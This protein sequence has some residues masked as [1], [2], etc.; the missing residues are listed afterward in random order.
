MKPAAWCLCSALACL[1]LITPAL[2]LAQSADRT[3]SPLPPLPTLRPAQ[4]ITLRAAIQQADQANRSLKVIRLDLEAATIKRRAAYAALLPS[5]DATLDYA[6]VAGSTPG[7]AQPG[8]AFMDRREYSAGL[9]ARLPIVH[10]QRWMNLELA[11]LEQETRILDVEQARQ[12]LLY[13][14]A[15]TYFQAALLQRLIAVFQAQAEA[16]SRHVEAAVE[17]YRSGVGD[18]VD[19]KRAQTDLISVREEQLKAL[20]AL[21]D[22]RDALALLIA[23]GQ[24]LQPVDD[25]QELASPPPWTTEAIERA[26]A[27]RWDLR[28]SERSV[29][30]AQQSLTIEWLSLVPSLDASVQLAHV[31]PAHDPLGD[32]ARNQWL[33]G[34]VLTVPLLDATVVPALQDRQLS[35][36]QARLHLE[37]ARASAAT[38]LSRVQRALVEAEQLVATARLK[39]RLADDALELSQAN[40]INGLG[41]ALTV[42]DARRTSQTAHVEL[43]TRRFELELRRLAQA[44]ATGTDIA[45]AL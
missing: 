27:Q 18:L 7:S 34:L 22:T 13:G 16:L 23:A 4:A 36:Q 8:T 40:Y 2:L 10:A 42:V 44:R 29:D 41:S 25:P 45:H 24:L 28:L 33:A 14:V 37:D 12:A 17:R 3:P 9:E 43:E 6:L 26:L 32:A 30:L 15:E 19:V 39:A 5:L 31:V 35:V 38:E 21:E 1:G 20:V 11:R